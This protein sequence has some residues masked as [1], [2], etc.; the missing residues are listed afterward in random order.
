MNR[1]D[2]LAELDRQL[3]RLPEPERRE[4]LADYE[5]HFASGL[6]AGKSEGEI[7]V[8][9]GT[10]RQVAAACFADRLVAKA[11]SSASTGAKFNSLVRALLAMIGLG[12]FNAVFV[13]GPFFGA[14]GILFGLW[15]VAVTPVAAGLQ[16]FREGVQMFGGGMLTT[17]WGLGYV[18]TSIGMISLAGLLTLGMVV[19]TRWFATITVQYVRLNF[20]II[21]R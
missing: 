7:A 6:E 1:V 14:V 4:I 12:F 10:P 19:V 17:G 11:E 20:D 8:A 5:E 18:F 15:A 13:L 3:R 2:Y 9:L 21:A 16:L